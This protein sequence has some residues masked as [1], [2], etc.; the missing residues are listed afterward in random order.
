MAFRVKQLVVF[1]FRSYGS[2]S[3]SYSYI[4]KHFQHKYQLFQRILFPRALEWRAQRRKSCDY[5]DKYWK[6]TRA[7]KATQQ[8]ISF[9]FICHL[10]GR[11]YGSLCVLE[12]QKFSLAFDSCCTSGVIFFSFLIK[13]FFFISCSLL[14]SPLQ[15]F[16][17]SSAHFSFC[18]AFVINVKVFIHFFSDIP[19]AERKIDQ[20]DFFFCWLQLSILLLRQCSLSI[21]ST[22]EE[23]R[24][25]FFIN[26][27]EKK[28]SFMTI[29]KKWK[30]STRGS[31]K[32]RRLKFPRK[33]HS[34]LFHP[35][36]CRMWLKSFRK[37]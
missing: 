29:E 28:K 11:S 33:F 37:I 2:S 9:S 30:I 31:R 23:G 18:S 1:S 5:D 22:V 19:M 14:F 35:S 13:L 15:H 27:R 32:K 26:D 10:G 8:E 6:Q 21:W 17:L 24:N 36:Q 20:I 3:C 4:N 25:E 7:L 34:V 12:W 16:L